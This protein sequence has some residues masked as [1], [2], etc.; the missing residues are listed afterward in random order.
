MGP[1]KSVNS[2]SSDDISATLNLADKKAGE[3]SVT[4]SFKIDGYGDVWV[5]GSYNTTV[6]IE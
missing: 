5:V 1:K 4:A 6:T 2:V 3:H